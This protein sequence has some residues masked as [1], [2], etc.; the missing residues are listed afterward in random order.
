[1]AP[2]YYRLYIYVL[3]QYWQ[4]SYKFTV[5]LKY[6][7]YKKSIKLKKKMT[8]SWDRVTYSPV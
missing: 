5:G 2:E 1:M 4:F 8:A 3:L 7:K 6:I